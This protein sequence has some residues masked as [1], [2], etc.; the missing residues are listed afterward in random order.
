MFNYVRVATYICIFLLPAA[1][2][3]LE[4][5]GSVVYTVLLIF[6]IGAWFTRKSRPVFQRA[7]KLLMAGFALYFLV[8]FLSYI[9]RLPAGG[10][11][12]EWIFDHEVRFLGFLPIYYLLLFRSGMKDWVFWYG[13]AAG[14]LC[15][16]AY[17]LLE[18]WMIQNGMRV[19]GPYNPI[20][21]GDLALVYGF[22]SLAGIRYFLGRH[23]GLVVLPFAAFIGG[24][25]AAF[26]SGTL[27]AV[28]AV[29]LLTLLFLVQ[30]GDF[31]RPW[32]SR[33]AALGIICMALFG[34]YQMSAAPIQD[35]V[36]SELQEARLFFSGHKDQLSGEQ[37]YRLRVWSAAW[38]LFSKNPAAGLGKEA[39]RPH[40]RSATGIDAPHLHNLYLEHLVNYGMFGILLFPASLLPP[41]LFFRS[42]R[43]ARTRAGKDLSYAGASLAAG[44]MVF[45]FTEC[46][47]YRNVFISVYL[48]LI[49]VV[50]VLV[51]QHEDEAA[52]GAAPQ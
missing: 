21:F 37:A 22:M 47:F 15:S 4:H 48:V 49:G 16:A 24:L 39:H 29:P 36:H 51:R 31:K 11:G 9:L 43:G 18:T 25:L 41:L 23:R 10:A 38:R 20:A 40:I 6:G 32:T 50:F 8:P 46:I 3:L 44:Y 1:A 52:Q 30:L 12:P 34:Y 42:A 33:L 2:N 19:S 5:G 7:D 28:L 35:R 17:A 26:F 45:A 27:G 14:A 13:A